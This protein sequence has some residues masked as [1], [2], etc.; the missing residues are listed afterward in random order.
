MK[1]G[2][3]LIL[4]ATGLVGAGFLAALV[5]PSL[6]RDQVMSEP[7]KRPVE[8]VV[9]KKKGMNLYCEIAPE[10]NRMSLEEEA[11]EFPWTGHK[12]DGSRVVHIGGGGGGG[13]D[14]GGGGG[15]ELEMTEPPSIDA[16]FLSIPDGLPGRPAPKTEYLGAKARYG[17]RPPTVPPTGPP[18]GP[19]SGPVS[20]DVGNGSAKSSDYRNGPARHGASS[21]R[22]KV[23]K[24]TKNIDAL[25]EALG[26]ARLAFRREELWIIE[27]PQQIAKA[28]TYTEMPGSGELRA[29]L[30]NQEKTVPL[31]LKHT[32]VKGTISAYVATVQVTQKYQNPYDSKI[33]AVYVFPLPQ[34]AAIN[35]FIMTV[36]QRR[37]RGI[38]RERQEARRIYNAARQQGHV[39]SLLTQERPNIFTQSVANIEP[40]KA[41]EIEI[42]YFNT[43][44]FS[45]GEYEFVFPMVVGPRFNPPGCTSG[46]AAVPR[47]VPGRSSQQ[48]EVQYLRPEE[49]SGHDIALAVDIDAGVSLEKVWSPSHAVNTG[50]L[51]ETR[52]KVSLTRHDT[53]PN[54]DFVLRYKVAGTKVKAALLVHKDPRGRFFTLML[55]PPE[56]LKMIEPT[57]R[58]MI[59]VLD[60]SGSM[61]GEPIRKAKAAISRALKKLGKHDTFQIIRFSNNASQLGPRPIP[62]TPENV[63]IGQH[64]LANL[65]GSGGTMMIEGIKA[66]LD[67]PHAEERFRIVSFMTD[68][69]IG[70]D[71][72]ILGEVHQRIGASRIF[73]FGVGSSPNRYLLERMALLGHGAVAWIGL[74]GDSGLAAV[75]GFYEQVTHPALTD[76]KIDWDEMGATDVYP[77]AKPDLFVGRPIILTGRYTGQGKATVRLTGNVAGREKVIELPVDLDAAETHPGLPF[78]WARTRIADLADRATRSEAGDE[79][80]NG[81]REVAL[82]FGLMSEF[83]SFVAVD[84]LSKTKG[85]FGTTVAVPVPVPEGV[86]YDT[87]VSE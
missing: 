41:I 39:A 66:A 46:V 79:L 69:F 76:L 43:L 56:D 13:D 30:P 36:G 64:Y 80:R 18:T 17:A 74:D 77:Q 7:E 73:S 67:F 53:I 78:V 40:G 86:R 2:K 12:S 84:S 55:Q 14:K 81:I 37:I 52:A 45:K 51:G 82:E 8:V 19:P 3:K 87:T 11:T 9:V 57:P 20:G 62:A 54:K 65:S 70:N 15:E 23:T 6:H 33:E 48:T 21:I 83:T 31:P 42:R 49:R 68:G 71:R 85:G 60:C 27:Q 63:E 22:G 59:F 28:P 58:E 4:V 44:K 5:V 61:R 38:I 50:T 35:E 75:D 32:D 24:N 1:H 72:Q 29:K 10:T 47:G 25:E 16:D 34:N 26:D